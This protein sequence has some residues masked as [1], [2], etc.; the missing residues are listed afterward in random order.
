MY[1]LYKEF[2]SNYNKKIIPDTLNPELDKEL[3][4][5]VNFFLKWGYLII[6]KALTDNQIL[7]LRKTFNKTF[8]KLKDSVILNDD[9]SLLKDHIHYNLFEEY[10]KVIIEYL[11]YFSL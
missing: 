6:D 2:K 3:E 4:N 8:K 5:E 11:Q 10:I 9:G 1:K 7:L